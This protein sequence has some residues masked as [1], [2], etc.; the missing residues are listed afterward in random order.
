MRA[1]WVQQAPAQLGG[2]T[3][4]ECEEDFNSDNERQGAPVEMMDATTKLKNGMP[5]IGGCGSELLALYH[6][7]RVELQGVTN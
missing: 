5:E 6:E 7:F 1:N 4:D 2:R 3:I